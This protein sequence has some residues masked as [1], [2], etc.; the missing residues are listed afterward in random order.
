M[1]W[2]GSKRTVSIV[3]TVRPG[4]H[5]REVGGQDKIGAALDHLQL[6]AQCMRSPAEVRV[7]WR[8]GARQSARG[9]GRSIR[10]RPPAT[11]RPLR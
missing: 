10:W 6:A 3:V 9:T 2:G 11:R 8:S 5:G 7:S 1:S 4:A